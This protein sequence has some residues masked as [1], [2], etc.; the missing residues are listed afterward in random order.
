MQLSKNRKLLWTLVWLIIAACAIAIACLILSMKSKDT[1]RFSGSADTDM[2]HG[3][4]YKINV[5]ENYTYFRIDSETWRNGE[6]S[7][8][9]SLI[10]GECDPFILQYDDYFVGISNVPNLH[11]MQ[12]VNALCLPGAIAPISNPEDP[13]KLARIDTITGYRRQRI[14]LDEPIPL[15]CIYFG[16]DGPLTKEE[17]E[18]ILNGNIHDVSLNRGPL[19]IVNIVFFNVFP[20]D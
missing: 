16:D 14:A 13:T 5:T 15:V 4:T 3:Y 7:D 1:L 8:S 20:S 18:S 11:G 9:H 17:R 19:I 12:T 2:A 6:R 10:F